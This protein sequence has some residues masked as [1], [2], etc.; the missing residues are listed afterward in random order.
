MH[1]KTC[2]KAFLGSFGTPNVNLMEGKQLEWFQLDMCS[3]CL[4]WHLHANHLKKMNGV[5]LWGD[6]PE[7]PFEVN[8]VHVVSSSLPSGQLRKTLC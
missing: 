1:G 5:S 3:G 7:M 4:Y 6:T 8:L 2:T